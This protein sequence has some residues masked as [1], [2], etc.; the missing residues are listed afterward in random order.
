MQKKVS[1]II[2]AYNER[3]GLPKVVAEMPDVVD[4]VLVVDDGSTDGTYEVAKGMEVRVLRHKENM[5]KVAAIQTGL[6]HATG[7]IVVL[8]DADFTYPAGDIVPLLKEL[9]KGADLVIGSRFMGKIENMPLLNRIGNKILSLVVTFVSGSKIT[10]SQS[11]FRGFRRGFIDKIK[12]SARSLEFETEMTVKAAKLGYKVTE[13]PIKYR[14]R[15][16][17]SKL[18]P[19]KDGYKMFF[20]ILS[21]LYNETSTLAKIVIFPGVLTSII[22][23]IFGVI[24][25]NEYLR[26][27]RPVHVYY[28]LLT[29]LF[30][31]LGAQIF[32]LG[33][34]VDNMTKKM[35]RVYEVL[36]K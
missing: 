20:A 3:E 29:V 13:V 36:K 9:E 10:D 35:D 31:V 32:S 30:V 1:V 5:G 12:V 33:L 25:V 21:I 17:K 18:N 16:G 26:F 22:G 6:R 7:G 2:P 4:E 14:R 28:P 27:G 15:I 23:L 19:I 11:G 24:A 8:T 34:I